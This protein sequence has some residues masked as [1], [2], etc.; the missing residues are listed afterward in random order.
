M[1]AAPVL[2][3]QPPPIDPRLAGALLRAAAASR[4]LPE[5]MAA[6]AHAMRAEGPPVTRF[7]LQLMT[8]HPTIR[9]A[10]LHWYA[11]PPERLLASRAFAD[12]A[13]PSGL[14]PLGLHRVRGLGAPVEVPGHATGL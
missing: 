12:A 10:T 2:D 3:R 5:L 7:G 9:A 6:L 14:V 13:G 11:G 8:R 4:G 1:T